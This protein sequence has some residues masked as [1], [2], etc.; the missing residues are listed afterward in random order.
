MTTTQSADE[1]VVGALAVVLA[2]AAIA[3]VLVSRSR[4]GCGWK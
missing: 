4:R 2:I 1:I 3:V